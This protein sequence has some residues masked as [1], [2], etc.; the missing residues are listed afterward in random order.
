VWKRHWG[1]SAEPFL[2]R[3]A[4]FIPLPGH[5]EAVARLV[6]TIEAG[7]R[8]A[9]LSGASGLG[10]TR[11]LRQAIV[12]SRTPS[13][14]FALVSG[15]ADGVSL[16]GGLVDGLRLRAAVGASSPAACWRSLEKGIRICA[17]QGIQVVLAVD[18]CHTLGASSRAEDLPRLGHL[19]GLAGGSVT[20]L[21]VD[22]ERDRQDSLPDI[23]WTLAVR[24]KPLTRSEVEAYLTARLAAA[25]GTDSPFTP[26]AITR[27]HALS[28]GVPRGLDRLASLCLMAGA[29][30]GLEAISLELVDAVAGECLLPSELYL[31]R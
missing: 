14:R 29:S 9:V 5:Q 8:L 17:L 1:L 18:D 26:R 22:G 4:P 25:G 10:K 24:L 13:R 2:D 16:F 31:R 7:Q 6:H 23:D 11:V 28:G 27:L 20:V 12:E 15:P 30:R 19:G 21:L 3:D